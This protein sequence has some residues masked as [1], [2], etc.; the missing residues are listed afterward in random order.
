MCLL[1][2]G[3]SLPLTCL[4]PRPLHSAC[5]DGKVRQYCN[6]WR[7]CLRIFLFSYRSLGRDY[8]DIRLNP[9]CL[10]YGSKRQWKILLLLPDRI[11]VLWAWGHVQLLSWMFLWLALTF[12]PWKDSWPVSW[13]A[14]G[15]L[16]PQR[17]VAG[18]E[19]VP[20]V[21]NGRMNRGPEFHI[22]HPGIDII[23]LIFLWKRVLVRLV[24]FPVLDCRLPYFLLVLTGKI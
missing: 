22:L 13:A 11:F 5:W 7:R 14:A 18:K 20:F 9:T 16:L 23:Q 3:H 6:K 19:R 24:V 8:S 15:S 1:P 4:V 10:I 21:Y 17:Q 12:L 2:F